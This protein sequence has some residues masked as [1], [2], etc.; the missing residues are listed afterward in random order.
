MARKIIAFAYLFFLKKIKM[1]VRR[2]VSAEEYEGTN[3]L[4]TVTNEVLKRRYT[5]VKVLPQLA[6]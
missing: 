5:A 1:F 6:Y 3:L 4:I 2:I